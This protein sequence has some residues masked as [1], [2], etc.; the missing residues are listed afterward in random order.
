MRD[1]LLE[2][3]SQV[4]ALLEDCEWPDKSR[5]FLEIRNSLKKP[6]SEAE[7]QETLRKLDKA[8]SG[9]GSFADLPLTPRSR[10]L[11]VAKAREMQWN[12]AQ[13]L[14]EAIERLSTT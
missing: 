3:L 6:S 5:W 4:I 7:F 2:L 14:G 10:E 12:L 8:I 11:T 9:M 1:E 13:G